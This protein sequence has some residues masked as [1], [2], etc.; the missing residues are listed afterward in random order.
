MVFV[1]FHASDTIESFRVSIKYWR[2]IWCS[3]TVWV[4]ANLKHYTQTQLQFTFRFIWCAFNDHQSLKIVWLDTQKKMIF[5]FFSPSRY[6]CKKSKIKFLVSWRFDVDV[7][8]ELRDGK[9]KERMLRWKNY[10]HFNLIF[11]L[12]GEWNGLGHVNC[13]SSFSSFIIIK[14]TN[15]GR[16]VELRDIWV[17]H[18]LTLWCHQISN[19]LT[20]L[21]SFSFFNQLL[22]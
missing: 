16:T 21:L 7:Q 10:L 22:Q 2:H 6:V 4:D 13:K 20:H 14:H 5:V 19:I 18:C 8:D 9:Q 17:S 15:K 12:V 1:S 3:N 11:G